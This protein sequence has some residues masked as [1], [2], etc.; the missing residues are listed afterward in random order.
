M[1]LVQSSEMMGKA[2]PSAPPGGQAE[3]RPVGRAPGSAPFLCRWSSR[4]ETP[5]QASTL[6]LSPW[7][8]F[9]ATPKKR[10]GFDLAK[11]SNRPQG[12]GSSLEGAA[13]FI[14]LQFSGDLGEDISVPW[15]ES[16]WTIGQ[17]PLQEAGPVLSTELVLHRC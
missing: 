3:G 12:Q 1:N 15:W 16:G 6:G 4:G 2:P 14:S 10:D 17:G 13:G 11:A 7:G 9:L 8:L 5:P